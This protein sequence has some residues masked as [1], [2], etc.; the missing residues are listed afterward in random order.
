MKLRVWHNCL[1]V[2]EYEVADDGL[3]PTEIQSNEDYIS[4]D[5]WNKLAGE[6]C[7]NRSMSYSFALRGNNE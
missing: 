6:Q 1:V 2:G 4:I 3:T 7:G 5:P